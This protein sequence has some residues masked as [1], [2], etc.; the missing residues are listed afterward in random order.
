MKTVLSIIV[1]CSIAMTGC[2]GKIKKEKAVT[3]ETR[4][5][6]AWDDENRDACLKAIKRAR[7]DARSGSYRMYVFGTDRYDARFARFLG[8][9][10][11]TRHGIELIV[12]GSE[13]RER[14]KCY[15]NEMDKIIL[16]TF[17]PGVLPEAEQEARE[18]FNS[19]K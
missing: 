1:V 7:V 2:A 9:Y 19:R 15:S 12:F 13:D 8:E 18:L 5:Q 17:G 3:Q 6:A 16:N 11:K 14:S 4:R 10:M